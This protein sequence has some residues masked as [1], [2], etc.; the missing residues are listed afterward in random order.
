MK[1]VRFSSLAAVALVLAAGLPLSAVHASTPEP[2]VQAALQGKNATDKVRLRVWGFEVYDAVLHTPPG[3]NAERFAEQRFGL[4]LNYL[5]AFKGA[6]IAERSIDEMRGVAEFT[7]EQA[8][9]WRKAMSELFPDV[10]RGDRIT[11]VHVPG[12]GA[13]FYFNDRLLGDVADE[14]FSRT[15]FGIWLSPKTSQPRMRETLIG[16]VGSPPRTP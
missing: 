14:T 5:R 4:E 12:V 11:G 8:D 9:G 7:P 13:R 15:F 16:Q 10:K 2:T 3:F 6:D 1:T